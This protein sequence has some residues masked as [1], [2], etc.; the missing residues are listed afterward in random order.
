MNDYYP[1]KEDNRP[2]ISV[3]KVFQFFYAY[4]HLYILEQLYLHYL[5]RLFLLPVRNLLNADIN[6]INRYELN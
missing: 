1:D 4:N 2:H 6:L 5:N 3:V